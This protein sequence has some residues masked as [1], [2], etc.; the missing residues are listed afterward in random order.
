[1]VEEHRKTYSVSILKEW[2]EKRYPGEPGFPVPIKDRVRPKVQRKKVFL[3]TS[4]QDEHKGA[5][6]ALKI[7]ISEYILSRSI[8]QSEFELMEPKYCFDAEDVRGPEKLRDRAKY[9]LSMADYSVFDIS[10]KRPSVFFELGIAHALCKPWWMVWHST[11]SNPLDTSFLPGFLKQPL[12]IDFRITKAGN[13]SKKDEF[14]RKLLGGL[15]KESNF[16]PDPLKELGREVAL[17]PNSFYFAHSDQSYW[18]PTHKEVKSWL[19][20][21]GQTEL[22]LPDNLIG[23]DEAIKIC[24][25]IRSTNLCLVDTTG[26]DCGFYYMVGYAYGQKEERIVVNLY[27]D[28]EEAI[29]MW[30]DMPNIPWN[31]QTMTQDIVG[32]LQEYIP[33]KSE[34]KP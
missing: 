32:R 25:C 17:Q 8:P 20:G 2:M 27:R 23:K 5:R 28:D 18:N 15:E 22:R 33:R 21:R 14:C 12:I 3:S 11:P 34:G 9:G 19:E 7:G 10:S 31:M 6:N 30:R 13:I 1:M 24:Y 26:L 16:S 4:F 29:H